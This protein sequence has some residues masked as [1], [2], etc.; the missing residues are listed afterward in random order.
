MFNKLRTHFVSGLLVLSPLFLTIIFFGYLVRLTDRLIV[1]PIFQVLPINGD[2]VFKVILTKMA[3]A[4][5]VVMFLTLVGTLAEKFFVKRAFK[6]WEG[7]L[8]NVPLLNIVYGSVKEIAAAFASD[9]KGVFKEVVFLEYPR[10][11]IYAMAF[12]TQEKKWEIHEKTGKEMVNVF[13]PSPPNPATG[14]FIF[15]PREELIRSD[16]T[17]EEGIRMVISGGAVVP[18]LKK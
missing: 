2:Q 8:K 13:V 18:P 7:L 16:M 5:F 3:I 1:N 17:I 9:K 15:V 10:K 14:F 12:V 6:A 4:F 11:G